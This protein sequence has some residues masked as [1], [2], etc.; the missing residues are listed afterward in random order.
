[1]EEGESR[2]SRRGFL[3]GLLGFAAATA[4][5]N[6]ASARSSLKIQY[7]AY[8]KELAL[9]IPVRKGASYALIARLY[10]GDESNTRAIQVFNDNKSL[11][12]GG[13][14]YIP[15]RLLKASVKKILDENK[16]LS[17]EID[18]Q[19]DEK[20]INTLWDVAQEFMNDR[21]DVNEKINILLILNDEINP[22]SGIV[23]EGQNI[24]VPVSLVEQKKI[25][26]D[27]KDVPEKVPPVEK[28][29]PK[30]IVAKTGVSQNPY[31][32]DISYIT[33]RLRSRDLWNAGRIRSSGR[34]YRITKHKGLDLV[35]P[36]GTKLYA[37]ANS[38]ILRAGKDR[39]RWR[40]GNIVSYQTDN[41]LIVTYIHLSKVKVK[42]GQ[43]V[44]LNDVLGNVGI[45]G[46]A[47]KKNPHVH[48]QVKYNG[49]I[50]DPRPYVVV[51]T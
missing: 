49:K 11:R 13:I 20:G 23:F 14:M 44:D 50:V 7:T 1:M 39:T 21:F 46:N 15:Q 12:E 4:F 8:K 10:T 33:K 38:T 34:K 32:V 3:G 24:L 9:K 17:F 43:K 36:I 35:S 25:I 41:G 2:I 37:I 6:I 47:S 26:D 29:K 22:T 18:E 19:G 27:D 5:P 51:D 45:T 30:V 28:P 42:V 40:N 48:I 31:R 16:F